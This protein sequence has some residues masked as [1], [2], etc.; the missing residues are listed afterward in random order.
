[1][2]YILFILSAFL[3]CSC[4]NISGSGQIQT[5]NRNVG[6]F[7]GVQASGSMDIE[8]TDGNKVSVQVEADDNVL[9]YILT[10]VKG[11]VLEV[12]YKKNTSFN[13]VHTRVYVTA[14]VFTRLLVRGSGN[15]VSKNT[16]KSDESIAAKISGSGDINADVDAPEVK[17]EISGSGNLSLR[18]RTKI[19]EGN[20]SGSGDLR[21]KDLLSENAKI[22]IAGSGTAHVYASV[23][24][25]ASTVGSGDI[26]YSGNPSTPE[27]HKIG[28]GNIE[29]E[30]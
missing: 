27:I 25:K 23:H 19:F 13:N 11:G 9:P 29:P 10:E 26:Y 14:P 7:D 5:E 20:I 2:R 30:R 22:G 3:F 1:M 17:A 16:I 28:S 12:Y 6:E 8:V 21:C 15:I 18:G 24:L 4:D